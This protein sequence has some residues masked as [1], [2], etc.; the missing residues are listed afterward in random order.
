MPACGPDTESGSITFSVQRRNVKAV[1]AAPPVA[2][3][4]YRGRDCGQLIG[5]TTW[6][7]TIGIPA[8]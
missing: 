4:G 6:R 5:Y 2:V 3:A 7:D 1:L 8:F